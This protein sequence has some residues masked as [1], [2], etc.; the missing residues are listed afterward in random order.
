MS[1]FEQWEGSPSLL[2]SMVEEVIHDLKPCHSKLYGNH[3]PD[4]L[5]KIDDFKLSCWSLCSVVHF[6]TD[7]KSD[8]VM[9][10]DEF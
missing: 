3:S 7:H 4:K 10:P 2:E 5:T 1:Q 8:G 9:F 6:I